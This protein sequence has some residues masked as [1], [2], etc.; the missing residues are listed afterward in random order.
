MKWNSLELDHNHVASTVKANTH[1]SGRCICTIPNID[2]S[3]PQIKRIYTH[4]ARCLYIKYAYVNELMCARCVCGFFF[5]LFH[6]FRLTEWKIKSINEPF[7]FVC[8]FEHFC[9][10][11][12]ARFTSNRPWMHANFKW[13]SDSIEHQPRNRSFF[14]FHLVNL[15]ATQIRMELKLNVEKGK[16]NFGNDWF[17]CGRGNLLQQIRWQKLVCV[18]NFICIFPIIR[19]KISRKIGIF[20]GKSKPLL[21]HEITFLVLAINLLKT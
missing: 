9:L 3:L 5:L 16:L 13:R 11:R 15:S 4:I 8:A 17:N 7:Y 2:T 19:W 14:S 12:F 10:A 20:E 1:R 21:F 6:Y 18:R